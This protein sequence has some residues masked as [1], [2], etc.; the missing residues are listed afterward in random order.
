MLSSLKALDGRIYH[1][2]A[3]FAKSSKDSHLQLTKP[4]FR[5]FHICSREGF[6]I[7]AIVGFLLSI[8]LAIAHIGLCIKTYRDD[9]FGRPEGDRWP[10]FGQKR[11]RGAKACHDLQISHSGPESPNYGFIKAYT[12]LKSFWGC[13]HYFRGIT[14]FL[15]YLEPKSM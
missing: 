1:S 5:K 4:H 13:L 10:C 14:V 3:C 6:V 8:I 9:G 12:H 7:R 2:S 11:G 15:N